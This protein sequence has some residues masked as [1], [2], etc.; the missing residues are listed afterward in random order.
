L[1]NFA[2]GIGFVIAFPPV[3]RIPRVLFAIRRRFTPGL[4]DLW[5][6]PALPLYGTIWL[7]ESVQFR[8]GKERLLLRAGRKLWWFYLIALVVFLVDQVSKK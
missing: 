7:D 2:S 8:D 3:F 1:R 5:R 4:G 6:L